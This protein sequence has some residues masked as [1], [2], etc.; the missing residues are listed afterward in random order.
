MKR[1]FTITTLTVG[2][3]VAAFAAPIDGKALFENTCATCHGK[4]VE[5]KH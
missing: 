1:V 3:S 2:L 5:K 4:K